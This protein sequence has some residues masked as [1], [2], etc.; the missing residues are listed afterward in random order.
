MRK[1]QQPPFPRGE[2][3]DNSDLFDRI[4]RS[5]ETEHEM[6][7]ERF[8]DLIILGIRYDPHPVPIETSYRRFLEKLKARKTEDTAPRP[9]ENTN[10]CGEQ[11]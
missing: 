5:I 2:P 3:I 10:Q 6:T 7:E 11:L 4:D 9:D 8:R 1:K